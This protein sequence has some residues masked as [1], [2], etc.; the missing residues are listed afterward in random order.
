MGNYL[1]LSTGHLTD[2]TVNQWAQTSPYPV[3][4]VYD[5]GLFV[6]VPA[7][8]YIKGYDIPPDMVACLNLAR[9]KGCTLIRF[10][11]DAYPVDGLESYEW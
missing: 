1:E 2:K 3:I 6:T 9:E 5:Y 10:D 7:E 8:E 11:A 4:A